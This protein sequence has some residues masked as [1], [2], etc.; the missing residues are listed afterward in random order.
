MKLRLSSDLKYGMHVMVGQRDKVVFNNSPLAEAWLELKWGLHTTEQ[1]FVRDPGYPLALGRFFNLINA[2]YPFQE[3]LPNEDVPADLIPHLVRFRFRR[4]LDGWPVIQLG[5]GIATVNLI[6]SNY[7]WHVFRP[8]IEYLVANVVAAYEQTDFDLK[9]ESVSLRYRNIFDYDTSATVLSFLGQLNT[10]INLP[11][12]EDVA[13][14]AADVRFDIPSIVTDGTI[15]SIRIATGNRQNATNGNDD[16]VFL[17]DLAAIAK[18]DSAPAFNSALV[19]WADASH[20]VL[21]RWFFAFIDGDLRRALE[22]L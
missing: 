12:L 17:F 14:S 6:G 19:S 15:G 20:E 3:Q 16:P 21:R 11:F 18:A 2:R 22:E 8:E 4:E 9:P 7:S 10:H 13:L 5:P 1:G